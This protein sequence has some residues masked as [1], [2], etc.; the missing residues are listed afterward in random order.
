LL[1]ERRKAEKSRRNPL[2]CT[3][4][5]KERSFGISRNHQKSV[6]CSVINFKEPPRRAAREAPY[7]DP[8]N[9]YSRSTKGT[10]NTAMFIDFIHE[11]STDDREDRRIS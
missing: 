8:D 7:S 5:H 10:P 6:G 2:T 9:T 3:A 11:K 4:A 1:L